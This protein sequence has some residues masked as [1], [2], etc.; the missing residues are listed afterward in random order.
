MKRIHGMVKYFCEWEQSRLLPSRYTI[1]SKNGRVKFGLDF[2]LKQEN[3]VVT[4][5]GA[6]RKEFAWQ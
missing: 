1:R 3:S 6:N 5:P 2:P 4:L